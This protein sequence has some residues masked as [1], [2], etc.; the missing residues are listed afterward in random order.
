LVSLALAGLLDFHNHPFFSPSRQSAK[1]YSSGVLPLAFFMRLYLAV[2]LCL[3]V[4]RTNLILVAPK[5]FDQISHESALPIFRF[6]R[7]APT[8]IVAGRHLGIRAG[9]LSS[10]AA[11]LRRPR[12]ALAG[13]F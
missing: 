9:M 10:E 3:S 7:H 5:G 8:P 13:F 1:A 2:S 4:S 11:M 6:V 12:F